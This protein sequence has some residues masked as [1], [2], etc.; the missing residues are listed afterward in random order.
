M[1][2]TTKSNAQTATSPYTVLRAFYWGGE[3]AA[4]GSTV[5]L[6]AA[7][8]IELLHAIKIMPGEAPPAAPEK[9]EAKSKA[10]PVADKSV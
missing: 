2:V 1:A 5:L 4:A 6:T 10:A 8:A 9:S 3:V 7:Q